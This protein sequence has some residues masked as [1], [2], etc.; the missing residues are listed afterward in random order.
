M[1]G[2][3]RMRG[4]APGWVALLALGGVLAS[5]C[6]AQTPDSPRARMGMTFLQAIRDGSPQALRG[7]VEEHFAPSMQDA[8]S[9]EEHLAELGRLGELARIKPTLHKHQGRCFSAPEF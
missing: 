9:M 7:L 5:P 4:A 6:S 3:M 2:I 8:F 1:R